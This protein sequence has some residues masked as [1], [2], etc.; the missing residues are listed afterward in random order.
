[1]G[2]LDLSG[3]ANISPVSIKVLGYLPLTSVPPAYRIGPPYVMS[4]AD[5]R[6]ACAAI[7]ALAQGLHRKQQVGIATMVKTK[8]TDPILV[9]L[10]PMGEPPLH[11]VLLQLPFAGDIPQFTLDEEEEIDE[12][13]KTCDE[14]ID[15]LMMTEDEFHHANI[16]N[17]YLRSFHKTVVQRVLD[18]KCP[19]VK[20]RTKQ[21]DPM[22]T[23]KDVLENA[24]PA[25]RRF[26]KTFPLTTSSPFTSDKTKRKKGPATYRDF[27]DLNK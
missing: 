13:D 11:L 21:D 23:P 20:V 24:M 2:G 27:L 18:P 4:G 8:D 15:A 1:M 10:F 17:P 6:P 19:V 12:T 22:A 14:M 16:A 3:L 26:R 5:S 25:L 7:A 9:G